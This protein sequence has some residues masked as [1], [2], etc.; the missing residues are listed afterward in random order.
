MIAFVEGTL[1]E[2]A[3]D[4]VVVE[5]GGL[6]YELLAST[7]TLAALP[8]VGRRVRL[9]T[10]L[11]VRDEELVLYGFATRAER[12][13]FE[14]L[15]GV[16]GVGPKMARTV[17]SALRPEAL[18]QAVL[19]GDLE[20][21]TVVPGVGKKL[22]A[23]IVVELRDRLGGE[24]GLPG[25]GPVVEVREALSA[26]GLSAREIQEAL[27]GLDADGPVEEVLREALRRIGAGEPAAAGGRRR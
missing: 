12:D 14:L 1:A 6:G 20:A 2:R 21:V 3:A 17:L 10:R 19:D 15:I 22:A 25:E 24:V 7:S 18:R 9:L 26:M 11:Q 23:R 27:A 8:A 16:G 13:L 4:R 5:A